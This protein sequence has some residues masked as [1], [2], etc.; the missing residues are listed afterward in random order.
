MRVFQ[1]CSY[2]LPG[3]V[4]ISDGSGSNFFDP[5]RVRSIFCGSGRVGSAIYCLGMNLENFS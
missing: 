1:A 5:G 3:I 2:K 4:Y